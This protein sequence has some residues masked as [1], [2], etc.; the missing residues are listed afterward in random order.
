MKFSQNYFCYTDNVWIGVS[1]DSQEC[2]DVFV[3]MGHFFLFPS[4]NFVPYSYQFDFMHISASS[5]KDMIKTF[6]RF[7]G[8]TFGQLVG[9]TR[10]WLDTF[11]GLEI[12][13]LWHLHIWNF[14][15]RPYSLKYITILAHVFTHWSSMGSP[16]FVSTI[17]C[18][19]II[20]KETQMLC[21]KTKEGYFGKI[22]S[23]THQ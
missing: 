12:V 13:C 18:H 22:K 5:F 16:S 23:S 15:F 3:F 2:S 10:W 17:N 11:I 6:V 1:Y 19:Y 21:R 4:P 20:V 8:T 7:T 14:L 9:T